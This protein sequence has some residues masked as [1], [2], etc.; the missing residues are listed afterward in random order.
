MAVEH[1]VQAGAPPITTWTYASELQRDRERAATAEQ[2]TKLIAH[3]GGSFG[4]GLLWKVGPA[5]PQRRHAQTP[6]HWR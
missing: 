2:V 3:R 6:A 5:E 4:Q 1:M